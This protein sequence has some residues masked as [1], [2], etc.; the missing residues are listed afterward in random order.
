MLPANQTG[1]LYLPHYIDVGD[2]LSINY[3]ISDPLQ[4]GY[5]PPDQIF[6]GDLDNIM[7]FSELIDLTTPDRSR[8]GERIELDRPD[9]TTALDAVQRA[10]GTLDSYLA[11]RYTVPVLTKAGLVPRDVYKYALNAVKYEFYSEYPNMPSGV[12]I[13]Y[14]KVMQWLLNVSKG[15]ALIPELVIDVEGGI[16]QNPSFM[17]GGV[18]GRVH[19]QIDIF[20]TNRFGRSGR[21]YTNESS[22]FDH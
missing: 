11:R 14:Q 13:A 22:R 15:L 6:L 9:R 10:E 2:L 4:V 7:S 3:D 16:T 17:G 5:I 12:E 8:S 19:T 20:G 18:V 21:N 1:L